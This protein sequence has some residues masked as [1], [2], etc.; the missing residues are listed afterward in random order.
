MEASP[1]SHFW[2]AFLGRMARPRV[3]N[4]SYR[5]LEIVGCREELILVLQLFQLRSLIDLHPSK[6]L[7]HQIRSAR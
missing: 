6:L 7:L 4:I 2:S 3:I 5:E 1:I